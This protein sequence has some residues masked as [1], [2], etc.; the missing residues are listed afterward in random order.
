MEFAMRFGHVM[1]AV[2]IC[3]AFAH[4][5]ATAAS[6]PSGETSSAALTTAHESAIDNTQSADGKKDFRFMVTLYGWLSSQSTDVD[7]TAIRQDV[8]DLY[9]MTDAAAQFRFDLSYGRLRVGLDATLAELSSASSIL[10]TEVQL[11]LKQKL[12]DMVVGVNVYDRR[13]PKLYTGF[14]ADIVAIGRYWDTKITVDTIRRPIL[15][16]GPIEITRFEEDDTRID[17]LLGTVLWWGVTDTVA[18]TVRAAIGGFGIGDAADFTWDLAGL[19]A[20]SVTDHF[21]ISLGYRALGYDLDT[22]DVSTQVRMM[23]PFLG[24]HFVF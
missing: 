18:F 6:Y 19:T 17:P 5:V 13:D 21:G 10:N 15:P 7:S 14:T 23:G 24:L 4:T 12:I 22:D 2:F 1:M 3:V 11:G 9:D 8:N 16:G 20:F